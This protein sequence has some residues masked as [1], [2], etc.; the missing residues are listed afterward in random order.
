MRF[1]LAGDDCEA[2]LHDWLA[3]L[4]F[5]FS[6]RRLVFIEFEV[7]VTDAGLSAVARGELIDPKRHEIDVEV[8]AITW[9]ALAVENCD[10]EWLAEIIVDV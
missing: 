2:L 1:Q 4:L 7:N 9:H 10:D 5:A 6:T 8:K 3:E